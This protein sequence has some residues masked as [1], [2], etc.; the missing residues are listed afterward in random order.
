M[1][2]M[3]RNWLNSGKTQQEVANLV[4]QYVTQGATSGLL[5]SMDAQ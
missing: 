2:S 5:T 4:K 3:I 1:Q